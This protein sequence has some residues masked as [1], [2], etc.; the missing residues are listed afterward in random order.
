MFS[1]WFGEPK[2]TR[3]RTRTIWRMFSSWFDRNNLSGQTRSTRT[4]IWRMFSTWFDRN[5]L[6]RLKKTTHVR[7]QRSAAC[8]KNNKLNYSQTC[9]RGN[10]STHETKNRVVPNSEASVEGQDYLKSNT[11]LYILICYRTDLPE[12]IT[13][14]RFW[15]SLGL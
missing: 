14:C 5:N 15:D 1:S 11:T 9:L 3:T 12:Y 10:L 13:L 2:S 7:Q 8:Y 4:I 6:R